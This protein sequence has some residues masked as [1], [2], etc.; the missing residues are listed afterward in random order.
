MAGRLLLAVFLCTYMAV[1]R[2]K[3]KEILETLQGIVR[4]ATSVV[5]VNFHGLRAA[6]TVSLRKQLRT[7][8]VRYTVAKKTLITKALEEVAPSGELPPLGGEVALAYGEGDPLI[9]PRESWQFATKHKES[10]AIIGGVF[11]GA[12]CTAEKMTLLAS[13]PSREALYGKLVYMVNWPILGLVTALDA[14]A[15]SKESST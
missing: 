3:K 15:K 2:E 10:F 13:I 11:E 5:F 8:G 12:Y 9:A 7:E 14:I 6:D 1:S 4:R